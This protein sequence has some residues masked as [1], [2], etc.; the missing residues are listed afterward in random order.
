MTEQALEARARRAAKRAGLMA[1]KSRWRAGTIDNRG[2]YMLIDLQ[3]NFAVLATAGISR[4][5]G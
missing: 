4:G 2:G 3:T 1:Y 5:R